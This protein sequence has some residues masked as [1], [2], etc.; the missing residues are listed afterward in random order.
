MAGAIAAPEAAIAAPEEESGAAEANAAP[1]LYYISFGKYKRPRTSIDWIIPNDEG[2][3]KFL[4]CPKIAVFNQYPDQREALRQMGLLPDTV[5]V[6]IP[7]GVHAETYQLMIGDRE[8]DELGSEPGE[9]LSQ[10]CQKNA[11]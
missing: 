8:E 9:Q 3:M 10:L 1:A 6:R 4:T 11:R 7:K 5:A 2:Y